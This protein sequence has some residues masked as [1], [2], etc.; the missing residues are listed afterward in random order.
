MS[1]NLRTLDPRTLG[2]GYAIAQDNG[3]S[4]LAARGGSKGEEALAFAME[5]S[6]LEP[7]ERE[8][9]FHPRRRWRFDFAWPAHRFAV[10]V[11][12]ITHEGG[13]HQRVDGFNKDLEKYEAALLDGWKVYRCSRVMIEKGQALNTITQFVPVIT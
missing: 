7:F 1:R 5:V 12:G 13:R 10:E 3:T 9:R 2:D 6:G 4:K 8:Y 11:E